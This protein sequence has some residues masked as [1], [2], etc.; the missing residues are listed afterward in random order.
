MTPT[1]LLDVAAL[2]SIARRLS[3][4]FFGDRREGD[5]GE[6]LREIFGRLVSDRPLEV[7]ITKAILAED[8]IA[9]EAS[10]ELAD[11]RRRIRAENNRIKDN[12]QRYV[13]GAFGKYLQENIVTLRNGRYVVPVKA[14]YKNEIKGLVH[15]TSASGATLFI[16]PLAVVD[17]NNELKALEKREER[18][19]ER[20]LAELSADCAANSGVITADYYNATELAFIFA[21][22]ELSCRTD[23]AEPIMNDRKYMLLRKARHPLIDRKKVVRLSLTWR[24]L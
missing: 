23:S 15:D 12:L 5:V 11:I 16:E 13:S 14:E 3:D 22:G 6:G 4:Y 17:S 20:I 10:P 8:M 9:D 2:L 19:I 18:E 24:K 21:K 7:K 1:E